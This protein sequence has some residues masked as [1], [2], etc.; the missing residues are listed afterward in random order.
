MRFTGDVDPKFPFIALFSP[1]FA[2]LATRRVVATSRAH[3]LR[4][5]TERAARVPAPSPLEEL[6][7][8]VKDLSE[9]VAALSS[10]D[11]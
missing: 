4:E 11:S 3:E 2:V 7:A 5:R 1:F 9:T 8:Q 6:T 10:R